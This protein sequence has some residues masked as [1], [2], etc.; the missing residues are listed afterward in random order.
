MLSIRSFTVDRKGEGFEARR[1]L[2]FVQ[3]QLVQRDEHSAEEEEKHLAKLREMIAKAR[4]ESVQ[5]SQTQGMLES[6]LQDLVSQH[7]K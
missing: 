6:E 5:R 4:T 2:T 3:Q 1:G 7:E